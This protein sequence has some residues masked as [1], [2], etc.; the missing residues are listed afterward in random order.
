MILENVDRYR[1]IEA[2]VEGVRV[3]LNYRGEPYSPA[4]F[5]GISGA[6]FHIAGIC[7]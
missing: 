6:A 3:I 5:Q 2:M 4:Y 7:P 1:V